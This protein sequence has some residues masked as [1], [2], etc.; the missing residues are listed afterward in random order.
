MTKSTT[1]EMLIKHIETAT[2]INTAIESAVSFLDTASLDFL[3]H[4]QSHGDL[5]LATSFR[6]ALTEGSANGM[7]NLRKAFTDWFTSY[8]PVKLSTRNEGVVFIK[9]KANTTGYQVA[10]ATK[11]PPS[12]F[13]KAGATVTIEGLIEA[14]AGY[15]FDERLA[16][17]VRKAEKAGLS[18]AE[19]ARLE[20]ITTIGKAKAAM[21]V[22]PE[23]VAA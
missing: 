19:I 3:R 6:N 22:Q 15:S 16:V 4:A 13:K 10:K 17:A 23:A 11:T 20:T 9:D 7:G 1:R 14:L 12:T 21:I 5:T 18:Q 2:S 8:A